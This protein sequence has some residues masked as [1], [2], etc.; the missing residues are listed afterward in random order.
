MRIIL[1]S[2]F[3][4]LLFFKAVLIP[5]YLQCLL[6]SEYRG[7]GDVWMKMGSQKETVDR[8]IPSGWKVTGKWERVYGTVSCMHTHYFVLYL[9]HK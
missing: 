5:V 8:S 4:F 7:R 6:L 2:M 3:P 1:V 9:P